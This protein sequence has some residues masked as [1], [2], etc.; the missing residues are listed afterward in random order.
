[1]LWRKMVNRARKEDTADL[2]SLIRED[3]IKR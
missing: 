1:M 3:L 2:S